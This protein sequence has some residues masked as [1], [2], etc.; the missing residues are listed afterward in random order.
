MRRHVLCASRLSRLIQWAQRPLLLRQYCVVCRSNISRRLWRPKSSRSRA[1]REIFM[2]ATALH[3]CP[4]PMV[5]TLQISAVWGLPMLITN[6]LLL[7]LSRLDHTDVH[8]DSY[9]P[10]YDP[11]QRI[12][13]LHA[14]RWAILLQREVQILPTSQPDKHTVLRFHDNDLGGSWRTSIPKCI[15]PTAYI[16][17]FLCSRTLSE[18]PTALGISWLLSGAKPPDRAAFR[19]LS[20][21]LA[22]HP[23]NAPERIL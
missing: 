8:L 12:W 1:S 9:F 23:V 17:D 11:D 16:T 20:D 21:F 4:V 10:L 13:S 5:W 19:H 15:S 22:M 2:A 14:D 7:D 18:Y 6:K 3:R